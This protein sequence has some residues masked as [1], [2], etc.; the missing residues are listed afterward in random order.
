MSYAPHP[1]EQHIHALQAENQ[2]L[3]EQ[4]ARMEHER[5]ALGQARTRLIRGGS[6]L[7]VPLLDRQRVVRSFAKLTQTASNFAGPPA[8]WPTKDQV[9][10]DARE[11]LESCMRFVIRRRMLIL[12]FSLIATAVPA[13]QL[14]LVVRQNQIIENQTALSEIQVYDVVSR[15]M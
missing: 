14:W 4:I 9:L 13:F 6:R 12:V 5:E 1:L 3:R 11:F 2:A 10:G 15:S 7:L 8:A